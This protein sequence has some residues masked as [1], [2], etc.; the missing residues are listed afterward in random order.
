MYPVDT[1]AHTAYIY[2]PRN[3][4]AKRSESEACCQARAQGIFSKQQCDYERDRLVAGWQLSTTACTSLAR[5][6][7]VS[8]C[9]W[10]SSTRWSH[11]T[12]SLV[13]WC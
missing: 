8:M 6:L 1:C 3:S 7:M 2:N 10:P 4:P 11:G 9:H 5:R 13:T 12:R